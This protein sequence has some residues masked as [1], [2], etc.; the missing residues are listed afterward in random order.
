[1]VTTAPG[2]GLKTFCQVFA[3]FILRLRSL[4]KFCSAQTGKFLSDNGVPNGKSHFGYFLKMDSDNDVKKIEKI[5][6]DLR[7]RMIP[8]NHRSLNPGLRKTK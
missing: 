4:S 7:V 5:I 3:V 2:A 8:S 1:M 6:S